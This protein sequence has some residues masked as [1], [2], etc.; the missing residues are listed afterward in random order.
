M[1]ILNSNQGNNLQMSRTDTYC[2]QSFFYASTCAS[3]ERGGNYIKVH[4]AQHAA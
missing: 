3:E 4:S 1:A 2:L